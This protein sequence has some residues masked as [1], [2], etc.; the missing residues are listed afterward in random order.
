MCE[1]NV[2]FNEEI[3]FKEAV[4]A[5][6]DENRVTVKDIL[7]YSK[8]FEDCKIEEVDVNHVRLIL[9]PTARDH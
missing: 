1:F 4:Y 2:I 9:S 8:E 3:V 6:A 5:K 7:G